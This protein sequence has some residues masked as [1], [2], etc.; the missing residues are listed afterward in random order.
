MKKLLFILFCM[1]T[2]KSFTQPILLTSLNKDRIS[3]FFSVNDHF[4]YTID[5]SLFQSDGTP[6]GTKLLKKT[7]SYIFNTPR[8]NPINNYFFFTTVESNDYI[9]LWKSDGSTANTVKIATYRWIE[10]LFNY[11][12]ELYL[13]I[14]D[15]IHGNE[16]WKLNSDLTTL[17]LLKDLNPGINGS[18]VH[19][20]EHVVLNGQ[21]YFKAGDGTG[22]D[23]WKTDGTTIG[24]SKA[25]DMSFDDFFNLTEINGVIFFT[26]YYYQGSTILKTEL[27]KTNGTLAGTSL[28]KDFG[29]PRNGLVHLVSYKGK[30]YFTFYTNTT[31]SGIGY[32]GTSDGT[33]QG[34]FLFESLP[35]TNI[36]KVA[37][38][39]LVF[40]ARNSTSTNY[41]YL[42]S[43]GTEDGTSQFFSS[44]KPLPY[45]TPLGKYNFFKDN[46]QRELYQSDYSSENSK[47]VTSIFGG[48][49]GGSHNLFT[50]GSKLFFTTETIGANPANMKLWSYDPT[51]P[52]NGA[53]YFTLVDADTDQD[54]IW[55][56]NNDYILK[57]FNKNYTIR[58][59]P[60]SLAGNTKS[61]KF[62]LN[63]STARIE[64][65]EP[66]SISGDNNGD[67]KTWNY[68]GLGS[69][70]LSATPYK[71][72]NVT[73]GTS[74]PALSIGITIK[75][76][77]RPKVTSFTLVNAITDTDIITLTEG[78]TIDLSTLP[79]NRL[80]IR[81]N[82]DSLPVS[83]VIFNFDGYTATEPS[84]P[85]ALFGDYDGDY[86]S[87]SLSVGSHTLKA[88]PYNA[89]NVAGKFL[90][91][92]F[93]A[94]R[95]GL[96]EDL[97]TESDNS[98]SKIKV[99]PNPSVDKFEFSINNG[100]AGFSTLEIFALDGSIVGKIFSGNVSE[101]ETL[102]L[103]WD[104]ENN[105]SGIYILK[106]TNEK[107]TITQKLI[108]NK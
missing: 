89:S 46:S 105:P 98:F 35:Y 51:K 68:S 61:V 101:N 63:Y 73:G 29:V 87:G 31:S 79:A 78:S 90:E 66:Y 100:H 14:N 34:T 20:T 53:P 10:I 5:D 104:S 37:N 94:F 45:F 103:K 38:N 99:M 18:S 39:Y 2:T 28:V 93:D 96:R 83:K 80:N 4:Y 108:L 50:A 86:R 12:S 97:Y 30:L 48:Y 102:N 92:T 81:A 67:F 15:G 75:D 21:L 60:G 19:V 41:S 1:F 69:Y 106:Y 44:N 40:S 43:D 9:S 3:Y 25:I 26:R 47:T 13:N 22:M 42:K 95:S 74:G 8:P 23:I 49:F 24:T 65:D 91:I 11:N 62:R 56:K 77:S 7:G 6:S 32:V 55:L 54:L 84:A 27:W 57:D 58:Y 36:E 52:S 17:S 16:L 82:L 72:I 76:I 33:S 70:T 85:Y 59:N 64:N 107:D 71:K 88:T